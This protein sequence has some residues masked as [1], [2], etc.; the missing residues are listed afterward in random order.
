MNLSQLLIK[1]DSKLTSKSMIESRLRLLREQET[2]YWSKLKTCL[3]DF[4]FERIRINHERQS[5]L[6]KK[7]LTT[8]K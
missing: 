5:N 8:V 1:H 7:L 4:L 3:N 6:N 2:Y